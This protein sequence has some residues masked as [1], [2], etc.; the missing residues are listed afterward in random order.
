[1]HDSKNFLLGGLGVRDQKN[2][3]AISFGGHG[4]K[5]KSTSQEQLTNG[6]NYF[7]VLLPL[8]PQIS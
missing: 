1:M 4:T 3:C 7:E 8:L 2:F 6:K 5:W